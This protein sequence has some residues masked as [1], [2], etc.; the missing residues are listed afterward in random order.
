LA[1]NFPRLKVNENLLLKNINVP[2]VDTPLTDQ[3]TKALMLPL[4]ASGPLAL[5][6]SGGPDSTQLMHMISMHRENVDVYVLTVDHG[7]R[8]ASAGEARHVADLAIALGLHH[9]ILRWEGEKPQ[10]GVQ[11]AAREARYR[12]MAGWCRTNG[13]KRLVTAHNLD[14]QAETVLMRL[15]RGSGPDGLAAMKPETQMYGISLVRPLLNISHSRLVASL[16]AAGHTA[17]DDPSNSDSKFERVRLRKAR[18]ARDQLGLEDKALAATARRMARAVVALE[19]AVERATAETV[20]MTE[21]GHCLVHRQGLLDHPL[22]IIIRTLSRCLKCIGGAERQPADHQVE[23][24]AEMLSRGVPKTLTL[25]GCRVVLRNGE[26][27]IGREF[28][29]ISQTGVPMPTSGPLIWDNRFEV[30]GAGSNMGELTVG[31]LTPQDWV[32]LKSVRPDLPAFIGHSLP[33]LRRNGDLVAAPLAGFNGQDE[34]FNAKF[35]NN[36]A[37]LTDAKAV[38]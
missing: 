1:N 37:R 34:A 25:A 6:V 21:F 23:A 28:G 19:D 7:L 11:A 14:D 33:A 13:I 29:R 26:V 32:C 22:E 24:L 15:A 8:E 9:A 18:S 27:V 30:S 3:E 16:A 38:L 4:F 12:L 2:G 10:S 31:P 5:A 36:I 20:R 35:L 17:I